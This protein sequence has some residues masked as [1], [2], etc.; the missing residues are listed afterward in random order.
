MGMNL[1]MC[2]LEVRRE[3]EV[4]HP[5]Q[6]QYRDHISILNFIRTTNWLRGNRSIT[7]LHLPITFSTRKSRRRESD[8]R[9]SIAS[10]PLPPEMHKPSQN[11]EGTRETPLEFESEE[12]LMKRY[13]VTELKHIHY[14]T[15]RSILHPH[16]PMITEDAPH[17]RWRGHWGRLRLKIFFPSLPFLGEWESFQNEG[18]GCRGLVEVFDW[19]K[20]TS[21]LPLA[22]HAEVPDFQDC[23]GWSQ[24]KEDQQAFCSTW[25]QSNSCP[26]SH[27]QQQV[28]REWMTLTKHMAVAEVTAILE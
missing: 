23:L 27:T 3:H 19:S 8:R 20:E 6:S 24:F 4:A 14:P 7:G 22:G 2:I 15:L 26:F 5:N 12:G 13:V 16:L 1:E 9:P 17:L 18:A 21:F 11:L 28:R 25:S 10:C